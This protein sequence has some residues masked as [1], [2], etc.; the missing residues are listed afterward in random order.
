MLLA[1]QTINQGF[2]DIAKKRSRP[3]LYHAST[4]V[5]IYLRAKLGETRH[6]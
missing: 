1:L 4:S 2:F 6:L 5:V 3:A